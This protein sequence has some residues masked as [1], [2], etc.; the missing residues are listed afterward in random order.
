MVGNP[1]DMVMGWSLTTGAYP[2]AEIGVAYSAVVLAITFDQAGTIAVVATTGLIIGAIASFW[3]MK[4]IVQKIAAAALLGLLAFAVWSQR[5][6]LQ[7]CADKVV[8]SYERSGTDVS[9]ADTECSFFGI[10]V[11]ISDPRSS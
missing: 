4:S 2:C 8:A 6:A 7:D 5:T 1:D 11:T 10:S 9:V 3:V